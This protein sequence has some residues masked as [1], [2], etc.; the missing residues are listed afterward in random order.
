MPPPC[1]G[2]LRCRRPPMRSR[3]RP[4]LR[5]SRHRRS[6]IGV[7]LDP[8]PRRLGVRAFL[9]RTARQNRAER[10]MAKKTHV[11]ETPATQRLRRAGVAFSEHV[12]DYLEHGGTAESA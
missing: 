3:A 2:T 10:P 8:R 7:S 9:V 12:Y 6:E 4:A 5:A 1:R 11:S